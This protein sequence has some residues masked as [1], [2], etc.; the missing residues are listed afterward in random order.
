MT[1]NTGG[2]NLQLFATN[3][4]A[5]AV[6]PFTFADTSAGAVVSAD[7]DGYITNNGVETATYE[8]VFSA[9]FAGETVQ[10]LFNSLPIATP[11]SATFTATTT[12]TPEPAS[13][14]LLGSGLTGLGLISRRKF[15]KS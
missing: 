11:F 13:L 1:F 2:S 5:G 15:K 3:I 14:L 12:P 9:T 8:G 7:V 10:D 6:G 4:P